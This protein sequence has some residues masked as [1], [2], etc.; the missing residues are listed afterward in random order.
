VRHTLRPDL[1]IIGAGSAG[2]SIAAVASRFGARIVLVEAARMG[3]E[4]LNNGCVPSKALLAAAARGR[5]LAEAYQAM[6][7][8]IEGLAPQDSTARFEALGVEVIEAR[9]GFVDPDTVGAGHATIRARRFVLATGSRPAVPAVPGLADGPYLTNETLFEQAPAPSHLVILGA[10]PMGA[11]MAQAYRRL[12]VEV[13]LIQKGR[14]LPRDDPEFAAVL[15]AA[16][17]ADGVRLLEG[18]RLDR[19]R[20]E[21]SG[22]TVALEGEGGA[23]EIGGS[24]LLVAAGRRAHLD[25]LGLEAAGIAAGEAG[26]VVDAGLR[27]TNRRVF[28]VGDAVGPHRFTH[29]A[30]HHAGVVIKRALFRLP[31]RVDYRAVPR[32]TYTEP[33]LLQVGLTEAEARARFGRVEILR[34]P[35]AE[36]DRA[37][38][39]GDEAGLVKLVATVRGRVVGGGAVGPGA[40][41]F[42]LPLALMIS[43]RL[44]LGALAAAI[45]P[46]PTRAE[47]LQRA[48]GRHFAARLFGP[49]PRRLVRLLSRM[50]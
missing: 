8:A 32:V 39:E 18:T 30:G 29:L 35:F 46:Y 40:G 33:E 9:A 47:A 36:N 4:C 10:G 6:R 3:G 12:G 50:P 20:W 44:P 11:E 21:A 31:A 5:S 23:T 42:A 41:E 45:V 26:I 38:I 49:G 28:A 34:H 25:G 1:C 7:G 14:L 48:A 2:L 22:V 37:A 27:T 24:H 16:L 13:T 43:R 19:V 15:A 17:R